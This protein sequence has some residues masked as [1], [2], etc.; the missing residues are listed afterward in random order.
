M[1]FNKKIHYNVYNSVQHSVYSPSHQVVRNSCENPVQDLVFN[2]VL[3]AIYYRFTNLMNAK[4]K[5][6]DFK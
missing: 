3:I 2:G 4:L 1:S 5:S 6:Y